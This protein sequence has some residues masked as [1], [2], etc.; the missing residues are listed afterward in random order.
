[1]NNIE[2]RIEILKRQIQEQEEFLRNEK[3]MKTL[4]SK[5]F[6]RMLNW[7]NAPN[8]STPLGKSE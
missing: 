2:R 4:L 5:R 6:D 1:M 8:K 3:R 7:D